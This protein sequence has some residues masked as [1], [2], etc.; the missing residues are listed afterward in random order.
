MNQIAAQSPKAKP[1][2]MTFRWLVGLV[3]V[4]LY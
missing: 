3:Y 4:C 2:N 1:E